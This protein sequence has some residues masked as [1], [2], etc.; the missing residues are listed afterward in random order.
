VLVVT[1][2][3]PTGIGPE[4]VG[5]ALRRWAGDELLILGDRAAL[6]PWL[7]AGAT[8]I[9]PGDDAEPVEVASLRLAVAMCLDGRA[10]ALVTGPIHKARLAR[11]GFP[12]P[13]HTEFLAELCGV[14]HVTMAFVGGRVR[15]SLATVHLPVR[16][17]ADQLTTAGVLRTI[18]A[19]DAAMRQWIGGR[20]RLAV[21]GL[22]PH[23][24][25]QGLLGSEDADVVAPAVEAARSAGIDAYG[26]V[27][28]E[29]AFK[30]AVR[31]E[32]DWVVAMY[33]DQGLAPLKALEWA[34]SAD[35]RAVNVTLGLP[36]LR[37]GV[38]HGTAHDIAGKGIADE[39]GMIA[40]LRFADRHART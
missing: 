37:A 20:A 39:A 26:P 19:S 35:E 29:A 32:A 30:A 6:E 15:V 21:C 28:A 17:I 13:G 33:H 31:G 25:D 38:D 8:V 16:K 12:H 2:G 1:P 9:D 14:Q 34:G 18:V 23:A 40:A 36:I 10:R 5:K 11:R 22:N 27:S 3:D 24:G 4:V 7:P